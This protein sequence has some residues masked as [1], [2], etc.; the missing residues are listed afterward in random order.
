MDEE[1]IS[2]QLRIGDIVG[3][4]MQ[5]AIKQGLSFVGDEIYNTG[6]MNTIP[7]LSTETASIYEYNKIFSK[8]WSNRNHKGSQEPLVMDQIR[9]FVLEAFD[10]VLE[11]GEIGIGTGSNPSQIADSDM[12]VNPQYAQSNYLGSHNDNINTQKKSRREKRRQLE[13]LSNVDTIDVRI[14]CC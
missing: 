9:L 11:A 4:V 7:A 10:Q 13:G 12:S 8:S 1:K 5:Q 6:L 14:H 2:Y 3:D